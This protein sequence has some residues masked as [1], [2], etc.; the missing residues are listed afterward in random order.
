MSAPGV[1]AKPLRVFLSYAWE[2]DDYR[3]QVKALATRLREDGIDARLDA[4][5]AEGLTIPEFMSREAR[6]ADRVL[7]LCSP[8]YKAKVHAMEDGDKVTGVGW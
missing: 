2:S 4:W 5:H 7:I 1:D 3:N 6:H 8:T